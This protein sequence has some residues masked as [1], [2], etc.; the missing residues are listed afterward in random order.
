MNVRGIPISVAW[1]ALALG[2][3]LYAAPRVSLPDHL[4]HHPAVYVPDLI[5]PEVGAELR[6]LA[7]EMKE[8]PTNSN[9][10]K[11]YKTRHEHV[12]EAQPLGADGK[13]DHPFLVPN[14]NKTECILPGRIDVGRH[15][16]QAG[17]VQGLKEH[18]EEIVPRLLSFGRYIFDL[19]DFPVVDELFAAQHFQE[20]A[21][22]TCPADKQVLDPFQFNFIVQ[23]PGQTV[24]LHV[25]AVY[26]WGATRFDVPQWLLAAMQ[27][28]GLFRDRFIDQIQVVGYFH[29]WEAT[30]ERGGQFVY[31]DSESEQPKKVDPV[32]L[33]GSVV[34]GS[35]TVH[36]ATVYRPGEKAPLLEKSA[37]IKLSYAGG[38]RWELREDG[39]LVR[40]YDTDEL[41]W[42]I[43]YRAR[44]FESEERRQHFHAL[45]DDERLELDEILDTLSE[46]LVRR[47]RLSAGDEV[48]RLDLAMLI[49]DEF[50]SYPLP[51]DHATFPFNYCLLSKLLPSLRPLT[52][53][54]C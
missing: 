4:L 45:P 12:G 47:G 17:G 23:V 38:E 10:L 5:S 46:E 42:T 32:P 48:S 16:I 20:A 41:R 26:F 27:F 40:T 52:D 18:F 53:L 14:V 35:K 43:V 9:D 30:P 50:I 3:Y 7:K 6:R 1:L 39:R 15:Y 24:A 25:D 11:F 34:D 8:F 51:P 2:L 54:V 28:S 21:K 22:K 33:A 36:A 37:D 44:C 19:T 29:E 31:W 49:M 13:C